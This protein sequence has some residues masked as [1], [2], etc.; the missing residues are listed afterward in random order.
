MGSTRNG[1]RTFLFVVQRACK[2]SH[3][4]GF[5]NGLTTIMG[6]EDSA[7]LF[8]LW[9]PLCAAVE[10]IVA[11]DDWFNRKDNT[12]PSEGGENEDTIAL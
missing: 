2:L 4:P 3:L 5:R 7:T 6:P 8:A 1:A 11:G 10:L 9:T 12:S